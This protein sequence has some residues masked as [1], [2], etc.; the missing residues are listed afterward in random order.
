MPELSKRIHGDND[1]TIIFIRK[2][3]GE[4]FNLKNIP[5]DE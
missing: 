1:D 3:I 4:A 2:R 5:S